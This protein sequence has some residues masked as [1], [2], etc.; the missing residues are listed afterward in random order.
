MILES[1]TDYQRISHF[2][3][4]LSATYLHILCD[5][6]RISRFFKHLSAENRALYEQIIQNHHGLYAAP[7]DV[8]FEANRGD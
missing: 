3:Y 5:Y 8:V 6:Q 4:Y 2:F 1:F 7:I